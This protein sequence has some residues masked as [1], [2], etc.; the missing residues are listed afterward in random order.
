VTQRHPAPTFPIIIGNASCKLTS[1]P[2]VV[3][4]QLLLKIL[5]FII[6]SRSDCNQAGWALNAEK[7]R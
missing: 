3:Y 1:K 4:R 2:A 5:Q 7:I 6:I